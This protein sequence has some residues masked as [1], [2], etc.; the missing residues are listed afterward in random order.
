LAEWLR[1]AADWVNQATATANDVPFAGRNI[2]ELT[3]RDGKIVTADGAND[4]LAD[5]LT[6]VCGLQAWLPV[7]P[8]A[9]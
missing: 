2:E 7:P 9:I 4:G 8:G 3:L 6:P 1:G 5:C